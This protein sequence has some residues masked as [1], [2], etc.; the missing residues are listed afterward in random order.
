MPWYKRLTDRT[1]EGCVLVWFALCGCLWLATVIGV[2]AW[3][4]T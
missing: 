1:C 3:L 4:L 2:V